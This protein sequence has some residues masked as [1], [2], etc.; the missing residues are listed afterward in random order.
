MTQNI[1]LRVANLDCEHDAAAITLGLEEFLGLEALKV[2][3]K[4]AKVS[5]TFNPEITD[6]DALKTELETLGFAPQEGLSMPEQPKP[7]RNPNDTKSTGKEVT[8]DPRKGTTPIRW[9]SPPL[10]MEDK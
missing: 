1:E 9:G 2:Y 5:L 10:H 3:P 6:P 8:A 4:S 7:W